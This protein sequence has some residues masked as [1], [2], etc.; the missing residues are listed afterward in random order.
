LV[1]FAFAITGILICSLI[2]G[3]RFA[4]QL[5]RIKCEP[6]HTVL[7][8]ICVQPGFSNRHP[9]KSA[10][11]SVINHFVLLMFLILAP[12]WRLLGRSME[13]FETKKVDDRGR[14][15]LRLESAIWAAI[16]QARGRRPGNISRT[17]WITEAIMEKLR[18]ESQAALDRAETTNA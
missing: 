7:P 16:D 14:Q 13:R 1:F 15:S 10:P 12:Q 3:I 18:A 9:R 17:T 8:Q 6:S 11:S 5:W 4:K 2:D